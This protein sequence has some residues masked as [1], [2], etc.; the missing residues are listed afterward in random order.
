MVKSFSGRLAYSFMVHWFEKLSSKPNDENKV[1]I[2]RNTKIVAFRK[3]KHKT[4]GISFHMNLK[5]GDE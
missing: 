4:A 3:F 5:E 2:T 1:W